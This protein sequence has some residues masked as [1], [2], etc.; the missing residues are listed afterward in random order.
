MQF[1]FPQME[2]NI[3]HY[4]SEQGIQG[5][6]QKDKIVLQLTSADSMN[7]FSEGKE[8]FSYVKKVSDD[9][10]EK[11]V[12]SKEQYEKILGITDNHKTTLPVYY[13]K[14]NVPYFTEERKQEYGDSYA[15]SYEQ[16]DIYLMSFCEKG[17]FLPMWNYYAACGQQGYSVHF[18]KSALSLLHEEKE[19]YTSIEKVIYKASEKYARLKEE[20]EG[21]LKY[22]D[23]LQRVKDT[24][25]LMQYV[26]KHDAF[27]YEGETRYI[28][29]IPRNGRKSTFEIKFKTKKGSIVPYIE[30]ELDENEAFVVTGV[31]IGPFADVEMVRRNLEFYLSHQNHIASVNI[32]TTDIPVRF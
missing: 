17:D 3:F 18:N 5:I 7:D 23:Y 27:E 8:I 31:T 32:R 28:V 24:I 30:L 2:G 16:C 15:I 19:C 10:L 6:F 11:G 9:L 29:G 20:I 22:E 25:S 1:V 21:A 13:F 4:T 12:M 26:F 14:R